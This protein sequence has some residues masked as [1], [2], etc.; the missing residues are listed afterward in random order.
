MIN[1]I[2]YTSVSTLSTVPTTNTALFTA[3]GGNVTPLDATYNFLISIAVCGAPQVSIDWDIHSKSIN[4]NQVPSVPVAFSALC[5]PILDL[6]DS[7]FFLDTSANVHI[8]LEQSNFKTLHPISPHPITSI[9]SSY[10]H[11]IGISTIDVTISSGHKVT[12]KDVLFAPASK[13]CLVS[14]L[15]LNCSGHYTSH[16]NEDSFWLTNC[17]GTT[18]L[19]GIVYENRHLYAL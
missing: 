8:S 11:A 10:I 13:V 5:A 15:S 7:P 12:L 2:A 9:G 14:V 6:A 3:T 18:I 16:F 17:G 4:L 1:G 19:C